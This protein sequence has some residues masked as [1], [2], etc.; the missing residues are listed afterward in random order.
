LHFFNYF[1]GS[2]VLPVRWPARLLLLP[3]P[4]A[5][6]PRRGNCSDNMLPAILTALEF[7]H[8]EKI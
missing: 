4:H 6:Q 8:A 5:G 7:L 2:A 1:Y 3:V